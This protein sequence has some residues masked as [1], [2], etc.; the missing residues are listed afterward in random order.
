M[1]V[2][3]FRALPGCINEFPDRIRA[4]EGYTAAVF[5]VAAADIFI[6]VASADNMMD[7]LNK[8]G[9]R[10]DHGAAVIDDVLV[11]Q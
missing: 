3:I 6:D 8:D 11:R 2:N 4:G 7:G 5:T 1:R 10:D 9:K